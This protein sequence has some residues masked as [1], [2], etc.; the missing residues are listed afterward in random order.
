MRMQFTIGKEDGGR[1]TGR[2]TLQATFSQSRPD[3]RD[4]RATQNRNPQRHAKLE[5][6]GAILRQ[7]EVGGEVEAQLL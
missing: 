4:T 7:T 2:Q 3:G 1:D 6:R 5:D